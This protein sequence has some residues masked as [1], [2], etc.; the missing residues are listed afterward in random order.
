MRHSPDRRTRFH[1]GGPA[2]W[3]I[4]PIAGHVSAPVSLMPLLDI[5]CSLLS[6]CSYWFLR[7]CKLNNNEAQVVLL[8]AEC[9]NFWRIDWVVYLPLLRAAGKKIECLDWKNEN[10][11]W[12]HEGFNCYCQKHQYYMYSL[13]FFY[14][15]STFS[16]YLYITVPCGV[17]PA[18]DPSCG[19]E[20]K[21]R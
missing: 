10:K 8:A 14:W 2:R 3:D 20:V 4:R 7:W 19:F 18:A 6:I 1:R 9:L 5:G 17:L 13:L 15:S 11:C 21:L 16:I 12:I